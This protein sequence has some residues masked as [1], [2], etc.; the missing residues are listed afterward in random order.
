VAGEGLSFRDAVNLAR[1]PRVFADY[2]FHRYANPS[3]LAA[4]GLMQLLGS[5]FE[6]KE[7]R[8]SEGCEGKAA[9]DSSCQSGSDHHSRNKA[10]VMDLACG[11][12]HSSFL[13]QKLFPGLSVTSV[14]NDF[15]S[16]YL[17]KRFLAP[18][19]TYLCVDAEISSPFVDGYFDG[20]FCLDALHYLHSKR[21]VVGELKRVLKAQALLLFPHLHNSMEHNVVAGI[22]LD[23][24]GYLDCF[25]PFE[26][27]LFDETEIMRGLS[28]RHT[29]DLEAQVPVSDLNG[30][31]ALTLIAGPQ[32]IWR[33]H[34]RFPSLFCQEP[35]VLE[36]NPIYRQKRRGEDIELKLTWPNEVLQRECRA[37]EVI[38]P[39]TLRLNTSE[40]EQL[41]GMDSPANETWL[42]DLVAKYVLVPLPPRYTH[43]SSVRSH[44]S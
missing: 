7:E 32:D 13:M 40:V 25:S 14:D 41:A 29:L 24:E 5:L 37:V 38:L 23:P 18:E 11:A 15:V 4:A 1:K 17:A 28:E 20:V 10:R 30:A 35:S 39:G 21:A 22:P 9:G 26:A 16:L 31:Q 6:A 19:A 3:F 42:N 27:K 2:L 34:D 12:G 36:I 8:T 43:R 44:C 33:V